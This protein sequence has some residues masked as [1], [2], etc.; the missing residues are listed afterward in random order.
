MGLLL[1][2]MDCFLIQWEVQALALQLGKLQLDL[3]GVA[4]THR[5][6]RPGSWQ[7]DSISSSEKYSQTT[8][9]N[10]LIRIFVEPNFNQYTPDNSFPFCEFLTS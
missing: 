6:F 8:A 7:Q 9:V 10:A 1:L 2:L 3:N 4:A 5:T